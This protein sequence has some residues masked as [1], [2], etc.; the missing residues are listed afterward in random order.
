[1]DGEFLQGRII[2]VRA[3]RATVRVEGVDGANGVD[4]GL[5]AGGCGGCAH[6][7]GCGIGRL[8]ALG[9]AGCAGRDDL[10]LDVPPGLRAG[11][12]VRLAAP[13]AGLPLLAL[14]GYV[15]PVFAMLPGAALG[16]FLGGDPAA[17]LCAVAAFCLALACARRV[18]A[19]HPG[20]FS[21]SCTTFANI[22]NTEPHHER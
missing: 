6:A 11:D 12:R 21:F 7:R 19:R 5:P 22:A 17:A 16:R 3:G 18:V 14:L 20:L 4:E 10:E 1:M 2:A 9:R 15:F 13:R 8:A